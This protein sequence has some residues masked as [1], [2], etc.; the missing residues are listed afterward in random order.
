MSTLMK[1]TDVQLQQ[2]CKE[3]GLKKVFQATKK[4]PSTNTYKNIRKTSHFSTHF[5]QV[6]KIQK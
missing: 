1:K 6:Q 2:V 4:R 3:N 5:E